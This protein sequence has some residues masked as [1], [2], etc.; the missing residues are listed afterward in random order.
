[1]ALI[2]KQVCSICGEGTCNG[3][4]YE[5]PDMCGSYGLHIGKKIVCSSMIFKEDG[6]TY[7]QLISGHGD[8]HNYEVK[9]ITK[10]DS[11]QEKKLIELPERLHIWYLEATKY[12]DM[13]SK[14]PKAQVPYCELTESQKKID[15]YIANKIKSLSLETSPTKHQPAHTYAEDMPHRDFE[16][17]NKMTLCK[18]CEHLN[19]ALWKGME[20]ARVSK[21]QIKALF[22]ET[23]PE[24][25]EGDFAYNNAIKEM[26]RKIKE[27]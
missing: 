26:R 3:I 25:S 10:S 24:E 2:N 16:D 20:I 19:L 6:K 5:T 15:I 7:Y 11:T 22:L 18:L 27:L 17:H 8:Y 21:Q 12:L 23:L 1:M 4:E 13:D 14:N 9:E